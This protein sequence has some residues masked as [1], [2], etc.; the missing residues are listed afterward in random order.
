MVLAFLATVIAVEL[1]PSESLSLKSSYK[2][3]KHHTV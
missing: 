1:S 3:V 2:N